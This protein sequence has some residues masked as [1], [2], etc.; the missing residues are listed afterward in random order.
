MFINLIVI[1]VI[2]IIAYMWGARGF[3]SAFLHMVCVVIAATIAFAVW[4]PV[5]Y[6]LMGNAKVG[7]STAMLDMAWIIG[8]IGPFAAV[9]VAIRIACDK[10]VPTNLDFDGATN[11]IGGLVCGAVSGVISA[12][13]L[14]IALGFVPAKTPIWA[15]QP[16]DFEGNGSIVR[17]NNLWAPA[18]TLTASLYRMLSES[19]FYPDS[20]ETLAKWKPNM[21]DVGPLNRIT[22]PPPD[23]GGRHTIHPSGFEITGRYTLTARDP[24]E[25]LS[26]TI[27]PGVRQTYQY[28]DG[29][30]L[31][32]GARLEGVV[33][34]FGPAAKERTGAVIVG[35]SQVQML[36]ENPQTQETRLILPAA[37][38]SQAQ[39][40]KASLGRWRF[41][42]E[43]VFISSVGGAS[44]ALMAF[45]FPVPNGF[46]PIAV[47]VRGVR[48]D[49]R[50]M[51]VGKTFDSIAA[52]DAEI[53][54]GQIAP[55]VALADLN[56]S[57][58]VKVKIDSSTFDGPISFGGTLP[59]GMILQK[60][61]V[62]GLLL[63]D[64][65]YI[66][67]GEAKLPTPQ[68]QNRGIERV[69]QVRGLA[70]GDDTVVVKVVMD[71]T[72][73]QFGLLSSAIESLESRDY[74]P[75]LL[76]N[77]GQPYAPIGYV[78]E[79]TGGETW[80]RF[81]P[82]NPL[83]SLTEPPLNSISRSLPGNKLTLLYRVSKRV[84]I[85]DLV[86]GDKVIANF[87]KGVDTG[88]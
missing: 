25:L 49:L 32:G 70:G 37:M 58:Q 8:L 11:M 86:V 9:L 55:R 19:T 73:T 62:G 39:G 12:G 34:K 61:N 7:G 67:D 78:Y 26:D 21:A 15:Y 82:Q 77:N 56:R 47:T 63:N 27:N 14:V 85:T 42:A 71:E 57:G 20:G 16:M 1:A 66:Y 80:I 79:S 54:T 50:S 18:D 33:I 48:T 31:E 6:A 43:K 10:I 83:Q 35:N 13:V 75:V 81:T 30:N 45:E 44:E 28:I 2:G 5:A 64:E 87:D 38:I 69:L 3:F 60:D 40:D 17:R 74:P 88:Q 36:V 68:T 24:K 59:Y 65:G 72:N 53:K 52:R 4:E 23:G 84:K 76:D 46:N 22:F 51:S 29:S 41:N